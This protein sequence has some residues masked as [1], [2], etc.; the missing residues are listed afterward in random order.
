MTLTNIKDD[1]IFRYVDHPFLPQEKDS[2]HRI[3]IIIIGFL[4]SFF[5]QLL[6]YLFSSIKEKGRESTWK[7]V[8]I[9]KR[10]SVHPGHLNI[11]KEAS[12]Y[13]EVTAGLLTDEA[14]AS[15]KRSSWAMIKDL[16]FSQILKESRKSYHKR[17]WTILII[18]W[19]KANFVLHGDDW[20][21]G[22]QKET[23]Q[24]VIDILKEWE[25]S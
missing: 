15:Y 19:G 16:K 22:P 8:Y 2:P 25:A 9:G 13:G 1:Y 21:E 20:K 4:V 17:R 12:S 3:L 5:Q 7:K 10:R 23:R 18:C 6:Y 14:I 11:I 24:K